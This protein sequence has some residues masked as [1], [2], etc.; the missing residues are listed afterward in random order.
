MGNSLTTY[1][2]QIGTR[3]GNSHLR[4][5]T[6][7]QD[8]ACYAPLPNNSGII[9]AVADGA[10]SA[11]LAAI[12]SRTVA[13]HAAAMAWKTAL[14]MGADTDPKTCVY[15]AVLAARKALEA[16]AKNHHNPL[17]HY[18]TTLIV[19]AITNKSTA[20]AHIGDGA[21]IIMT[22]NTHKMMTIP[23]RGEYANETYFITME[24]YLDLIAYN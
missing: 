8:Y 4:D 16:K 2:A 5:A 18:H 12:A 10:G 11:P 24:E 1:S 22:E 23:A 7:N 6:P 3:T 21:S 17:E 13:T 9:G 15:E 14:R 20:V 19:A